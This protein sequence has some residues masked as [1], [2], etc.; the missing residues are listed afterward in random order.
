MSQSCIQKPIICSVLI[1]KG[2][3]QEEKNLHGNSKCKQGYHGFGAVFA[4][5]LS[6]VLAPYCQAQVTLITMLF[7]FDEK[8]CEI[9][10]NDAPL[11]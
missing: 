6:H 11:C 2:Q 1:N 7:S 5:L 8:S 4:E 10:I 9:P 3:C